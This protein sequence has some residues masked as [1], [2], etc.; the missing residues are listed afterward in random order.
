MRIGIDARNL[1]ISH[2]RGIGRHIDY[3]LKNLQEIDSGIEFVLFGQTDNLK[4]E[5]LKTRLLTDKGHRCRLWEKLMLPLNASLQKCDILHCPSNTCPPWSIIP[6][7]LTVHDLNLIKDPSRNNTE[8]GIYFAKQLGKAVEIAKS[9][10]TVSKNS[11][12][13]LL[14][15]FPS[16]NPDKV[17]V[18]YNGLD[19]SKFR[20]IDKNA[21]QEK[22]N[23]LNTNRKYIMLM[24]AGESF[25]RTEMGFDAFCKVSAEIEHDLIITS[26]N[27]E[28]KKY[29]LQKAKE[30]KLENRINAL[31]FLEDSQLNVL[32]NLADLFLFP[33]RF[34]GFG[35]PIL[36]AMACRTRVISN[37]IP[38]SREIAGDFALF[39]NDS[40]D[41]FSLGILK[42]IKEM[43]SFDFSIQD[44]HIAKF[45]WKKAAKR[46]LEIYKQTLNSL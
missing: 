3:L 12:S 35:F 26:L 8:R 7:I 24:G 43:P 6:I 4:H 17:H 34:E 22:L 46:T 13:E 41:S 37:D 28:L 40:V 38:T 5:F 44:K 14:E 18:V 19:T 11:R 15:K 10:I 31:G 33:S 21:I 36:E 1:L 23:F 9:I 45:S 27:D 32:Y 25:K 42:G 16:L 2:K 39:C 20:T 30:C 29:Y